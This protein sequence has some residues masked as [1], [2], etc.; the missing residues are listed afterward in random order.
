MPSSK[1]VGVKEG[2]GSERLKGK[3]DEAGSASRWA[4]HINASPRCLLQRNSLISCSHSHDAAGHD[5][6]KVYEVVESVY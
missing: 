5:A 6:S 4:R 2:G 3:Q 1:R